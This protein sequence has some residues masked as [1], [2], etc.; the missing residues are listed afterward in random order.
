M[1][2]T[3]GEEDGDTE[4]TW[5]GF[6]VDGCLL[7]DVVGVNDTIGDGFMDG[8]IVGLDGLFV[9]LTDGSNVGY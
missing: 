3:D 2:A 1:G 7:G 6:L 5:D 8:D 9:G 4:G